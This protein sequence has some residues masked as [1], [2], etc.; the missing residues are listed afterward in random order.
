MP[1]EYL[2]R[3][4]ALSVGQHWK[5]SEL[6]AALR[7]MRYEHATGRVGVARFGSGR[8]KTWSVSNRR[9]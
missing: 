4:T 5:A 6:V 2:D 9:T 3:A 7:K 8:V 1:S